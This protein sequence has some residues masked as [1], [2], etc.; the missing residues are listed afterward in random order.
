MGEAR[1]RILAPLVQR[2]R[3]QHVERLL[4]LV[5]LVLVLVLV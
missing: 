1:D 5:L 2:A 4:L 3:R